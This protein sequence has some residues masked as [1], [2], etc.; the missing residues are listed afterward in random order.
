VCNSIAEIAPDAIGKRGRKGQ[1][2]T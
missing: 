2:R 1:V